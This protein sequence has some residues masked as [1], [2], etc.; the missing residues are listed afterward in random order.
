MNQSFARWQPFALSLLRFITGLLLFQ[1]GVAKLFK[2][3]A[4]PMFAKV[5]L[6]S[7]YGAAGSLELILGALLM[8]GLFTRPVAFILSGEMAFAY[9]LGHVFKGATPVWLPLL[10]GGSLAIAMCFTCLYL[11]TTGGG[12]ISLDRILRRDR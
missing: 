4:V 11:V 3:P 1:Y 10:N 12:P 8:L 7:L 9:F 2:F 6:F 5:E